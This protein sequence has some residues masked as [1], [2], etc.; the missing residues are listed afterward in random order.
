MD[1]LSLSPLSP[2]LRRRGPLQPLPW[3]GAGGGG[4]PGAALSPAPRASPAL[5]AL[6]G[7]GLQAQTRQGKDPL[8]GA[9]GVLSSSPPQSPVARRC[10]SRIPPKNSYAQPRC[11][12]ACFPEVS[13]ICMERERRRRCLFFGDV[14][15]VFAI[16]SLRPA[17]P[18]AGGRRGTE[19]RLPCPRPG[20]ELQPQMRCVF[21]FGSVC[22]KRRRD[23][24]STGPRGAP[25]R[26][27]LP[28]GGARS[29]SRRGQAATSP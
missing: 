19:G 21:T 28:A 1:P 25:A 7:P 11:L 26:R 27:P 17:G 2:L 4:S 29:R 16:A 18:G 23:H 13:Q 5:W 22:P 6:R 10:F 9:I 3:A 20:E 24:G 15:F 14:V 12:P 8:L